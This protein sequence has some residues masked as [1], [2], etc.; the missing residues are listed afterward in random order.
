M[1]DVTGAALD[2]TRGRGLDGNR[3]VVA[4]NGALHGA[5]LAAVGRALA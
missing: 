4:T 5:V 2:F 3:G 1:T